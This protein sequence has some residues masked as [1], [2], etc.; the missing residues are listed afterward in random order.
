MLKN[1]SISIF[2]LL[3][4]FISG[5]QQ[6]YN[7]NN[8]E[9]SYGM[10]IEEFQELCGVTDNVIFTE[11]TVGG[12]TT[13]IYKEEEIKTAPNCYGTFTFSRDDKLS[14]KSKK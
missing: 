10:N 5:C 14:S 6:N 9:P 3:A 1:I 12:E 11:T 8:I 7:P 13:L 2:L 4:G